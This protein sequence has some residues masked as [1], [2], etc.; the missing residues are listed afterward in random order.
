MRSLIFVPERGRE[1]GNGE[2]HE[3]RH[4][5]CNLRQRAVS[6]QSSRLAR[7]GE[8]SRP[9]HGRGETQNSN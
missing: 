9:T 3:E 5:C 7:R 8:S 2:L 4:L 6:L 1:G